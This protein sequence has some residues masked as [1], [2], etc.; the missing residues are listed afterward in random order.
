MEKASV[1]ASISGKS[2][3]ARIVDNITGAI[4]QGALH[5]GDQIPTE[6]EMA[7]SL[8]VSR[9]SVREAIK[10]LEAMGVLD[11][12]R[13]EGTF[14]TSG[15]QSRM[16]D[17][18]LYGLILENGPAR[19]IIELRRIF[20]A[21]LVQLAVEKASADDIRLMRQALERLKAEVGEQKIDI[22][23]LHEADVAFHTALE[24]GAHNSLAIKVGQLINRLTT[25]TRQLAIVHLIEHG[26][27]DQFIKLHQQMLDVILQR[28]AAQTRQAVED[29]YRFWKKEF[30]S[31][32]EN[33]RGSGA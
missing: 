16:L 15:F 27:T 7:Q 5:P 6:S 33:G 28:D 32:E 26:E 24:R 29:H 18:M 8:G 17:P 9:N 13:A 22:A 1:F 19:E 11:I 14:V 3:V 31:D 21:G 30:E 12:K 20:E 25:P 4:V 2:V 10:I 23:R